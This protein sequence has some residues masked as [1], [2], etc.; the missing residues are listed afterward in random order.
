M[1]ELQSNHGLNVIYLQT[2]PSFFLLESNNYVEPKVNLVF[3][4]YNMLVNVIL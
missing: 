4:K 2:F 1:E 3:V